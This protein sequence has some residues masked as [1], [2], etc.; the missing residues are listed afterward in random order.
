MFDWLKRGTGRGARRGEEEDPV[1]DVPEGKQLVVFV[2]TANLSRSPMAEAMCRRELK[3]FE[4]YVVASCGTKSVP[5]FQPT[6]EALTV[7]QTH[8]YSTEDL[9]THRISSAL[10]RRA[11]FVFTMGDV[12][13]K[14]IRQQYPLVASKTYL[15]TDF[16]VDEHDRGLDVVD[17][18]E[19]PLN[20]YLEVYELLRELIPRVAD[21]VVDGPEPEW[22]RWYDFYRRSDQAL[23]R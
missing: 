15:I 2:C 21:F 22:Q 5:G 7:L 16:A 1:A 13:L 23:G 6:P 4:D 12:H 8:G 3:D 19:K 11:D 17:P 14:S 18:H 10:M 20:A 9:V